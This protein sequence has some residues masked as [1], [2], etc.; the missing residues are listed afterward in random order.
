MSIGSVRSLGRWADGFASAARQG[1]DRRLRARLCALLVAGLVSACGGGDSQEATATRN[2]LLVSIDTLRADRLGA[3]GY[4]RDTS[5]ALDAL[6]A[7]G[8]R[9][10]TVI[11]ESSWTLP[12][13]VSLFTGLPPALHGAT[14]ETAALP[15]GLPVLPEILRQHGFRTMAFTGGGYLAPRFGFSRGFDLYIATLVNYETRRTKQLDFERALKLSLREIRQIPAQVPFFLFVHTYI[16]HCPYDPPAEYAARFARSPP[17]DHIETEGRCGNRDFNRMALTPGQVRF[18]SDRYDASIRHADDLLHRFLLQ[19]EELG[20][21]QKTYVAVIS[22]HGEEFGEHGRIG[23]QLGLYLESLRVPWILAGP[24]LTPRVVAAPASLADVAPTLLELLE[25]PAPAM[26]GVSLVRTLRGERVRERGIFSQL[27]SDSELK[28]VFLGSHHLITA[29]AGLPS[30]FD[31]RADPLEQFDLL[32]AEPERARVLLRALADREER[33]AGVPRF[34]G[35]AA[36][37]ASA[38]ERERLR[39][40]G[41]VE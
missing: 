15:E 10:E 24:G 1:S 16:V 21:L 32:G 11:A 4:D 20:V 9:F 18:L 37:T 29:P 6:A 25:V 33:L 36:P 39:L 7:R 35:S 26:E 19:L 5:P 12:S 22:D 3:Y 27:G 38:D 8:V 30:L 40:L 17:E 2:L 28:S 31:W 41:Y 13:H 23:H 34:S 14:H